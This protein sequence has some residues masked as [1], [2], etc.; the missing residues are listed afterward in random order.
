MNDVENIKKEILNDPENCKPIY[1]KR[2]IL[3]LID[4]VHK[5]NIKGEIYISFSRFYEKLKGL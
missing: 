2:D 3:S 1:S 5:K 4:T